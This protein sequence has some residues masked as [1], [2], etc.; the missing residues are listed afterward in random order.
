[1]QINKFHKTA[2]ISEVFI[3]RKYAIYVLT[4]IIVKRQSRSQVG[5]RSRGTTAILTSTAW[6]PRANLTWK[7]PLTRTSQNRLTTPPPPPLLFR[8]R[9]KVWCSKWWRTVDTIEVTS[10][11]RY[12]EL[13][14]CVLY[15][16]LIRCWTFVWKRSSSIAYWSSQQIVYVFC[17]RPFQI[18]YAA[19]NC[20]VCLCV[21]AV[22]V[23]LIEHL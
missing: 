6:E 20:H 15:G 3:T 18:T 9:R 21:C 10:L 4:F 2:M 14:V 23:K 1:M 5:L 22:L 17:S 16:M 11:I 19:Y 13:F 12:V 8:R 7:S